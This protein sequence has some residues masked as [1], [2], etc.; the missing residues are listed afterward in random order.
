[1]ETILFTDKEK[2]KDDNNLAEKANL[3]ILYNYGTQI[4]KPYS[5]KLNLQDNGNLKRSNMV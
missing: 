5:I 1:M 2:V 4:L 3:N